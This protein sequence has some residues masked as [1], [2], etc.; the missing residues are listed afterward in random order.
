[1]M[2]RSTIGGRQWMHF[3]ADF[4]LL[5]NG[6]YLALAWL[7]GDA[8]LDTAR[9][10]RAGAHPATVAVFCLVTVPVGYIRFRAACIEWL[11]PARPH[12]AEDSTG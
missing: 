3:I 1:M 11:T 5:A 9:L 2:G 12:Q 10:L 8:M 6:V 4:C 7:S